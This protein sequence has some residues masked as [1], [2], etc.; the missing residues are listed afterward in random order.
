MCWKVRSIA[1]PNPG[2]MIQLKALERNI[3]GQ[4]SECEVMQGQWKDKLENLAKAKQEKG[5]KIV[6]P[7]DDVI[8]KNAEKMILKANGIDSSPLED[9][10]ASDMK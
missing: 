1:A 3:L 9:K 5:E 10:K 6:V 7:S 8:I 4:T 2:F